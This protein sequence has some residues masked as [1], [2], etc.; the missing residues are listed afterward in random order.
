M[1]CWFFAFVVVFCIYSISSNTQILTD[2]R[3]SI[4]ISS[5][6]NSNSNNVGAAAAAGGGGDDDVGRTASD[7]T[8]NNNNTRG[9]SV[10]LPLNASITPSTIR[11]D[12][13]NKTYIRTTQ[14][15]TEVG[16]GE[17]AGAGQLCRQ[18]YLWGGGKAGSTSLFFTLTRGPGGMGNPL[19]TG[20]F[21]R[22]MAVGKE[23]CSG[24]AWK[25]WVEV[26]KDTNLCH[27]NQKKKTAFTHILN[28]CPRGTNRQ[29]AQIIM[30]VTDDPKFLM[31]IRDPVERLVSLI[32][33]GNRRGGKKQNVET[34]ARLYVSNPRSFPMMLISQGS[35]LNALLSVVKDPNRV[36]VIPMESMTIDPQGVIDAVMDHVG[37][38]RW[39]FNGSESI[40]MNSGRTTSSSSYRY[41]FC[42]KKEC[43]ERQSL[44]QIHQVEAT[45]K[46]CN[47]PQAQRI[48]AHPWQ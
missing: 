36:L 35:A 46:T 26:T 25:S 8:E 23:P 22:D 27:N 9:A 16:T 14:A 24:R 41:K 31:L 5:S 1:F 17:G 10:S 7:F 39:A 34:A 20:P 38:Q 47:L 43:D 18:V 48:L 21:V 44:K 33:D 4:L 28:G 11:F 19:D 13:I 32:N 30:Q 15:G 3:Y 45:V 42:S 6:S 12:P 29:Y 37:G 2:V 40:Q